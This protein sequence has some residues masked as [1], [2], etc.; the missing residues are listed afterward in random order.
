MVDIKKMSRLR[1]TFGGET[2]TAQD[3]LEMESIRE[4]KDR[5]M[6]GSMGRAC[7]S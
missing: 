2:N 6:A 5:R 3:G 4:N 7:D 1:N